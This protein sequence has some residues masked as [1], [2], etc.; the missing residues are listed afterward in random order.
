[1]FVASKPDLVVKSRAQNAAYALSRVAV[2]A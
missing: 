1:M 2:L